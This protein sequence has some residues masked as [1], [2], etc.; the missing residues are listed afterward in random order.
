MDIYVFM[1]SDVYFQRRDETRQILICTFSSHLYLTMIIQDYRKDAQTELLTSGLS[2]DEVE[3]YIPPTAEERR[4]YA[5]DQKNDLEKMKQDIAYLL[6]Q[7]HELKKLV[8][9]TKAGQQ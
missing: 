4:N 5:K 7:V 2:K 3:R 1:F 9:E 6:E 8:N